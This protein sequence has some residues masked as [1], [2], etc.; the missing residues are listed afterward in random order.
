MRIVFLNPSAELGGAETA[1]LDMLAAL[2]EARPS[3][4]LTLIT[5]AEGPLAARASAL[6][7]PSVPL[8]FPRSLASLG[9]WGTRGSIRG[10]LRLGA[11]LG[12]AAFPAM[13]YA[14]RLRRHL[15]ELAPDVVHTNGLKM[16][17]LGARTRPDGARLIWHMHDYPD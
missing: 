9:E 17:L 6:G 1:L 15:T 3:W 13:R 10:R 2:R 12:T 14:S 4:T 5:S 11:A 8:P 7:I 16:H